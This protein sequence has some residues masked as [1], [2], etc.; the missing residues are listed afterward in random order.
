MSDFTIHVPVIGQVEKYILYK[1]RWYPRLEVTNRV[2]IGRIL[3]RILRDNRKAKQSGRPRIKN[4]LE[5]HV[6]IQY[7][8]NECGFTIGEKGAD[9][10]NHEIKILIREEFFDF[11]DSRNHDV[12]IAKGINDFRA[13]FDFTD[14]D[15]TIETLKK[16]YQRYNSIPG[17]LYPVGKEKLSAKMSLKNG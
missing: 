12:S 3:Y 16:A 11:M 8:F 6:G 13:K 1:Y 5:F 2:S 14:Q 10:F 9:D 7:G 15:L 17:I 4:C